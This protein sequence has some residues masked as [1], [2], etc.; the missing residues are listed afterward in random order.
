MVQT[1]SYTSSGPTWSLWRSLQVGGNGVFESSQTNPP[2][3]D[4]LSLSGASEFFSEAHS[5]ECGGPTSR[6][7]RPPNHAGRPAEWVLV[8][9]GPK[10]PFRGP[11][12]FCLPSP[13]TVDACASI[14]AYFSV[15]TPKPDAFDALREENFVG[16]F[17]PSCFSHATHTAALNFHTPP[18]QHTLL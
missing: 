8:E 3:S 15:A 9:I 16:P 10:K 7:K 1:R 17:D 2:L 12:R 14:I 13:S 11:C 4:P 6:K 18:W 5:W